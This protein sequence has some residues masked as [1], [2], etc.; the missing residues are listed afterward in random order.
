MENDKHYRS[1]HKN[2]LEIYEAVLLKK[3]FA[4]LVTEV[5]NGSLLSKINC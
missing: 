3:E 1:V 4:I 2:S 5:D